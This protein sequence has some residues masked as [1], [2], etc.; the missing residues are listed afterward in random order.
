VGSIGRPNEGVHVRIVQPTDGIAQGEPVGRLLVKSPCMATG[1][2]QDGRIVDL[3]EMHDGW[4]DTGDLASMD[5]RGNLFLVG[6]SKEIIIRSGFNVAPAEVEQAI[7]RHDGVSSCAVVGY[8]KR[9][10]DIEIVAFVVPT[11]KA[12]RVSESELT[13]HCKT[14]LAGYKRP[15]RFVFIDAIPL[16]PNGKI[17]RQSLVIA[18][19]KETGSP[20]G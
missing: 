13:R 9:Y 16:L 3:P 20:D 17:D 19:G 2:W 6:R 18:A 1:L 8:P 5:S 11:S 7:C 15:S 10:E 14:Q 4:L 12:P